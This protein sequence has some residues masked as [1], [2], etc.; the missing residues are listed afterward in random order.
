MP[1][2][3]TPSV[4]SRL[5]AGAVHVYTATGSVLGFL[6]VLAA[7][8]GRVVTAL[9]LGLVAMV[10]DGTDGM[11]ARRLRVKELV[12]WFD[13]ARLDDIV[14]YLTYV[15]APVVLLWSIGALPEGPAG[16]LLAALPLMA[17]CYQFCRVDAK[18]DD[19]TFLGFPSY[20]NVVAF[21]AVVLDL[22]R[23]TVAVVL[24]L[25][26]LLVFVPIRYLYPSRTQALWGLS[27]ALTAVW[28]G[29]YAVLLVQYPDP[30]PVVVALS[31][32][33]VGYYVGVSLWLTAAAAR[34]RRKAARPA[35]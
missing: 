23:T 34:R 7:V 24:V 21:Y 1:T 10:V 35:A 27:M 11:L 14:D 6:I 30:H 3:P 8:E 17:S 9:W 5:A 20:W 18:T 19:H 28:F 4:S 25:C 33:Y 32:A 12:P 13:G 22:G 16:W 31:L 29:T 2:A 15:F 26:A